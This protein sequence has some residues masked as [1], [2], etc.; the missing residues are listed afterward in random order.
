ML[1][2][3]M[4]LMMDHVHVLWQCAVVQQGNRGN[5]CGDRQSLKAV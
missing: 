1:Q 4:L 2:S 5:I 3:Q